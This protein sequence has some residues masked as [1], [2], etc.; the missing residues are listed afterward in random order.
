MWVLIAGLGRSFGVLSG[1]PLQYPC[2]EIS[3]DKRTRRA[4][5]HGIAKNWTQLSNCACLHTNLMKF[6]LTLLSFSLIFYRVCKHLRTLS[7]SSVQLCRRNY[8]LR[9]KYFIMKPCLSFLVWSVNYIDY[10]EVKC[11]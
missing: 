3:M 5:V 4:T 7:V 8:T 11:I 2:L 10:F 9:Y 1:N 6:P